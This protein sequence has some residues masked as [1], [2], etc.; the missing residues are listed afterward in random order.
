M[1]RLHNFDRY[2][3]LRAKYPTF[4]YEAHHI[5]YNGKQLV[6]SFVFS[7]GGQ[8][9][10][11]PV[12][13]VPYNPA[14]FIPYENLSAR[15]LDNLAFHA[16]MIELVSY[17]KAA[18]PPRV[19]IRPKSLSD[20]QLAFWRKIYFQGL[21]EFFHVNSI[22]ADESDF[23]EII[24]GEG[25]AIAPFGEF[26]GKGS[27]V[28]V[29]GGKDSAV[30]MELM[31]KAGE[32]WLPMVINPSPATDAVIRAAG[33]D[34]SRA[35]TFHRQ[36]DPQLLQLNHEGFLNGHTPFSALLAFYSLPASY[37][38]GRREIILSNESS[39]NEPTVP[40]TNI[41]HQYSKSFS[42]E[43]D[44]RDYTQANISPAFNY[45]S[46]LRPL[47]ELQIAALFSEMPQYFKAFRSCNAGSKTNS[48]C[49]RCP[50]CLFTF[51]ILSPFIKNKQL[52]E[53][54]GSNLT[55]KAKS[56]PGLAV[57]LEELTGRREIK[58]FECIGTMEEVNAA[59]SGELGDLPHRYDNQHFVPEKYLPLIK[60]AL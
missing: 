23:M 45:F 18:C 8:I 41:N 28:P 22:P 51:I 19:I 24:A 30:T 25:P 5:E 49:G 33:V 37:L 27:I 52:E 50:K 44:F 55:E 3:T 17:W 60:K 40:G 1:Q 58:P 32:D 12:V 7:I 46:L 59:L 35:I 54:F 13:S 39:A 29:G 31:K 53:I 38:A 43:K 15:A 14:I 16:G 10:F 42:F 20:D 4:V 56:D 2:L 26:T 57:I 11:R 21:G 34:V 48:W 47:S 9:F 36:I 6:F